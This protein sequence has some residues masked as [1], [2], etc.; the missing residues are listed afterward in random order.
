MSVLARIN[1]IKNG[2]EKLQLLA[3]KSKQSTVCSPIRVEDAISRLTSKTF[4]TDKHIVLPGLYQR[5]I[6]SRPNFFLL[7][8]AEITD[9]I[10]GEW[11]PKNIYALTR[12]TIPARGQRA[13]FHDSLVM[14]AGGRAAGRLGYEEDDRPATKEVSATKKPR[15]NFM[16]RESGIRAR[17]CRDEESL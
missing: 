13:R 3:S 12:K 7:R 8:Q 17:R 11:E 14:I 4:N 1:E 15:C 2:R 5:Y 9:Q 6:P 16:S 10:R